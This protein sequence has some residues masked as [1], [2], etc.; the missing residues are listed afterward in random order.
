MPP[1]ALHAAAGVDITKAAA[2]KI[3]AIVVPFFIINP[4]QKNRMTIIILLT[5][6]VEYK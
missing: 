3:A 6:E 4:S 1:Q 5:G 2:S